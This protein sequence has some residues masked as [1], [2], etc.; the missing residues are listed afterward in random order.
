MCPVVEK[1]SGKKLCLAFGHSWSQSCI[2]AEFSGIVTSGI[3]L[4][5]TSRTSISKAGGKFLGSFIHI[6]KKITKILYL[7]SSVKSFNSL[8]N[9]RE[10]F[11]EY[12]VFTPPNQFGL[13]VTN[14]NFGG[15]EI[16]RKANRIIYFL[17]FNEKKLVV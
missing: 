12:R 9:L 14:F 6:F 3:Q 4:I 10:W 2:P 15:Y 13:S 17:N 11:S 16:S 7:L 5:N 8:L 1:V